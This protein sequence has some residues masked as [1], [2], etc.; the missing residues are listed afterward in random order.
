MKVGDRV[1]ILDDKEVPEH[2]RNQTGIIW[3][4]SGDDYGD[5]LWDVRLDN[6]VLGEDLSEGHLKL[7]WDS[8]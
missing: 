5:P 1:L 4:K 3:K 2:L 6:D 8:S 7:L